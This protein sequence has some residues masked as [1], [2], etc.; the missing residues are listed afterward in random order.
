MSVL[1]ASALLAALALPMQT[2]PLPV[3]GDTPLRGTEWTLMSGSPSLHLGESGVPRLELSA[4]SRRAHVFAGCNFGSAKVST[5]RVTQSSGEWRPTSWALTRR[6]CSQD[7][8]SVESRVIRVLRTE[9]TWSLRGPVLTVSGPSG[10][11]VFV[12]R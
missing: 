2:P 8:M 5:P 3:G 12:A 10:S 11:L 6:A 7:R 1:A 9:G 4:D